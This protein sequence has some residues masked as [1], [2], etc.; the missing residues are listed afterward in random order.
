M[1]S[2]RQ[3]EGA[4]PR[5]LMLAEDPVAA[6]PIIEGAALRGLELLVCP[7]ASE[8]L[9]A[10]SRED[11][12]L[13]SLRLDLP[14]PDP[15]AE[16]ERLQLVRRM[17][18]FSPR[19]SVVCLGTS[20]STAERAAAGR[21]G[22]D[23][24]VEPT[25]DPGVV[26][27]AWESILR[28]RF[29]VVILD[30]DLEFTERLT[31]VA[32]PLNCRVTRVA[33]PADLFDQLAKLQPD[34]VL[35]RDRPGLLNVLELVRAIR[36]TGPYS[37]LPVLVVTD[38]QDTT[39]QLR[40]FA[41]GA[42]SVLLERSAQSELRGRLRAA[43]SRRTILAGS[44]NGP[45]AGPDLRRPGSVPSV[46]VVED[47]PSLLEMLEYSLGNQ[48]HRI[49]LYTDGRDALDAL[50]EL[51]TRGFRPVVL[52]DVDLPGLDGFGVLRE[53]SRVRPGAFQVII[54]TIHSGE[55]AQV[56]AIQT[57]AIDYII[58]PVRMPVVLAKIQRLLESEGLA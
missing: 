11:Y 2:E 13:V 56:L 31:L 32:A 16:T 33:E 46:I 1:I 34:A 14:V 55:A 30:A 43:L 42:D 21:F 51:D 52:L 29:D 47:D 15:D 54:T 18:S 41:A 40:A 49:D 58:K 57:G 44:G 9:S 38:G 3:P 24:Y 37:S 50:L 12:P 23:L 7:D 27:D 20:G 17:R 39:L 25:D 26:L 35:L 48:G 28:T 8:V 45:S 22:V 10:L 53:L 4:T 36:I 19:S 6:G 5:C